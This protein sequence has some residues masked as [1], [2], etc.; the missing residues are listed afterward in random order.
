MI[1]ITKCDFCGR[2]TS[3]VG[4]LWRT[5][6]IVPKG[7]HRRMMQCKYCRKKHPDAPRVDYED[8]LVFQKK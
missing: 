4:R 8:I 7:F 3:K 5:D 2:E 6:R 1:M